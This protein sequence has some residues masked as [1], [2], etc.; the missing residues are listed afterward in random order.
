MCVVY[1]VEGGGAVK[2]HDDLLQVTRARKSSQE[3]V[4]IMYETK[5][6][7]PG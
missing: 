6:G 5:G 1:I 3:R 4:V 7:W 2:S